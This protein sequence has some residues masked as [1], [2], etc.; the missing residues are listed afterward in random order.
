[1][2]RR[3][4]VGALAAAT[5]AA[6]LFAGCGDDGTEDGA[7]EGPALGGGTSSTGADAGAGAHLTVEAHDIEFDRD[8]YRAAAGRIDIDYTEEGE[9]PHSLVIEEA[10]GGDVDGFK[11]EVDGADT[12][13][14]TVDLLPGDY[15]LY[16]DVAGHRE[17]G[18][19]AELYV[20]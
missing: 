6:L 18:M 1:M 17:A 15:V 14:G 4:E 3:R 7:G 16:C 13:S 12:D 20:E 2:T 8:A 10:G 11:L 19:E 5:V 9:L